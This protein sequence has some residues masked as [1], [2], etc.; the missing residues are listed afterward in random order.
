MII[1]DTLINNDSPFLKKII[2]KINIKLT[3]IAGLN[4]QQLQLV[5]GG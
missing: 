2:L 5:R 3:F 4:E 1:N